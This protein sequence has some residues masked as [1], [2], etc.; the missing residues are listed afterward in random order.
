MKKEPK[1]KPEKFA[2]VYLSDLSKL[3]SNRNKEKIKKKPIKGIEGWKYNKYYRVT[4]K[5]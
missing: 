1:T 5:K 4:M 2:D 3:F